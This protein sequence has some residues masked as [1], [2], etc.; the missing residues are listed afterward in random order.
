MCGFLGGKV[1]FLDV[2]VPC[3]PQG[4]SPCSPGEGQ[5]L[6]ECGLFLRENGRPTCEGSEGP[7]SEEERSLFLGL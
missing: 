1:S 6:A 2:I 7:D 5:T 3:E 4:D